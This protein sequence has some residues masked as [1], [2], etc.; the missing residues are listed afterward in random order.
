MATLPGTC[1]VYPSFAD[2]TTGL[3]RTN[4]QSKG[5]ISFLEPE[6]LHNL[7]EAAIVVP[8][9]FEVLFGETRIR[10]E[11]SD[12]SV[13]T[14]GDTTYFRPH[15][16]ER[17]E[18][19]GDWKAEIVDTRSLIPLDKETIFESVKK[20]SRALVVHEDKVLLGFGAELTAMISGKTFRHLDGPV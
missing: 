18:K 3:L 20:A 4:M 15:V 1:I 9:G 14:Y 5:F 8:E 12:L 6:A 16:A 19:E 2:D 17:S 7:A 11:G 13:I 10:R